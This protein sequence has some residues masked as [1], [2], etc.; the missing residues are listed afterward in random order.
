MARISA[1]LAGICCRA[2][3]WSNVAKPVLWSWAR[4]LWADRAQP[5]ESGR[6]VPSVR[7]PYGS[8]TNLKRSAQITSKG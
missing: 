5:G 3:T 2:A 1:A 6:G 4:R 7:P 8:P